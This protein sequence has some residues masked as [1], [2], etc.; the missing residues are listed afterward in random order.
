MTKHHIFKS[1]RFW[2]M[3]SK[4]IGLTQLNYA[5][6]FHCVTQYSVER[7]NWRNELP[8]SSHPISVFLQRYHQNKIF[9]KIL[10]KNRQFCHLLQVSIQNLFLSFDFQG[11]AIF[12][13]TDSN[14]DLE[15]G[16][17]C[18]NAIGKSY[19]KKWRKCV[20]RFFIPSKT[21]FF[22]KCSSDLKLSLR[23]T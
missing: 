17:M 6:L 13:S 10:E 18:C 23:I 8:S 15:I 3:E 2:P 22:R 19:A 12:L 1:W 7:T 20:S 21:F 4:Q 5:A 9:G 14:F 11:S 16:V